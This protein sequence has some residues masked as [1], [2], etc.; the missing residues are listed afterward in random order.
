[1]DLRQVKVYVIS[2][3]VGKYETRLNHTFDKLNR[4]G[5]KKIEHVPS[6]PDESAT[7]SLSRTNVLI[8]EKEKDGTDP[9][10]IIE[11]DVQIEDI[12][13]D[14]MWTINVPTDAVAVYLGAS[15]WVYPHEYHTL[16]CGKNIRP[17]TKG[18]HISYDDRLVR[19]GGMT[20]THAILFID[21]SFTQTLSLCIRSYL[22]AHTPHD[23]I[24]AAAQQYFPV[25]AL[26]QIF[27]YQD[28]NEGGQELETR[29]V[30]AHDQYHQRC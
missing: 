26:K 17:T 4:S 7:D 1:M 9:F 29:L 15:K 11:D 20:S 24:I 6:V 13:T 5:F 14:E 8:F 25:Y 10:I 23:L 2:P 19:L 18:D 22:K 3:G 27:F 16:S 28:S 21:R 12:I 30:W